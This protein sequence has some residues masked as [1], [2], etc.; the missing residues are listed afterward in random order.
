MR[1]G[2][3]CERAG[4]AQWKKLEEFFVLSP[5]A[6]VFPEVAAVRACNT[7]SFFPPAEHRVE[8]G[9]KATLDIHTNK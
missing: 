5:P 1:V 2:S 4:G 6:N 3:T 8:Q 7:S 9:Q